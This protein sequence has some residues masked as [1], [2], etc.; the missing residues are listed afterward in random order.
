LQ[1][2]EYSKKI[3][4]LEEESAKTL[5]TTKQEIDSLKK[6]SDTYKRHH[7]EV[8]YNFITNIIIV[9]TK[10]ASRLN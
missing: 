10:I 9:N 8:I 6:L 7:D 4:E 1:I 3:R 5:I 2:D